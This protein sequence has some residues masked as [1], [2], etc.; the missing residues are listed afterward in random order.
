MSWTEKQENIL[1]DLL[2]E[3][4]EHDGI[5]I[6]RTKKGKNKKHFTEKSD[7]AIKAKTK[8]LY[9]EALLHDVDVTLPPPKPPETK[10]TK[11]E[12]RAA[13]FASKTK[14]TPQ[15]RGSKIVQDQLTLA[16]KERDK[17]KKAAEKAKAT[18]DAKK[19][20]EKAAVTS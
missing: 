10:P 2:I 14:M 20:A 3:G 9:Y 4:L 16:R 19:E 5:L 7:R 15:K 18:R 17:K 1:I 12:I 8:A 13:L 11:Q 6:E